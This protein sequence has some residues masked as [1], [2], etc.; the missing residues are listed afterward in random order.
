M[1]PLCLALFM[2]MQVVVLAGGFGSRLRPW[3]HNLPKPILPLLDRTLVEQVVSGISSEVIDEVI[4]AAGYKVEQLRSYFA[5]KDLGFDVKIVPE[6]KPLG[7]GGALYNCR[8][9]LSGTFACFN[10]DVVSSLDFSSML[11]QHKEM[12]TMGTLAL[13]EV[14][15]PTRFGIVGIDENRYV[16]K[17]KEKPGP[18]EVFSNLINAGSYIL[19]DEVFE[20]MPEGKSS[21]ERELFPILAE[22]GNL[23]G[24]PFEGY[25]IDAGTPVSWKDAVKAA[26][27]HGRHDSGVIK[28]SSW[29]ADS[30]AFS[31]ILRGN[32]M[33]SEGTHVES[34]SIIEDCTLLANS[35]VASGSSLLNCLVGMDSKIGSDCILKEVIIDHNVVVPDGTIQT[36][37]TFPQ[38]E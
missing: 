38:V 2:G 14:E 4:I 27:V 15:D 34:N 6:D 16:T 22:G 1:N 13:W 10:G 9:H 37:G 26:I 24:M 36:G 20:L 5:S 29:F 12:K 25:F 7:T 23:G 8:D 18:E 30:K 28:S 32:N 21:L 19:E 3:T 31:C 33:F 17:F 11:T 35:S